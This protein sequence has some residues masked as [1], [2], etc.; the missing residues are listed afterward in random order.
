MSQIYYLDIYLMV[1]LWSLVTQPIYAHKRSY[2]KKKGIPKNLQWEYLPKDDHI[3]YVTLHF[4]AGAL[5]DMFSDPNVTYNTDNAPKLLFDADSNF[6]LTASISHGFV[7]KWDEDDS[8]L[9]VSHFTFDRTDK[10]KIGFLARSPTSKACAVTFGN[11]H[12]SA[13][14][15]KEPYLGK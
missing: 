3:T 8:W 9:L 6:A 11:I 10:L 14:K 1:I 4:T 7:N 2:Q 13:K 12:Y 15:I 5:T